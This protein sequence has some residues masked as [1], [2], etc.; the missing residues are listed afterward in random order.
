MSNPPHERAVELPPRIAAVLV[1]F[2]RAVAGLLA[3]SPGHR[4]LTRRMGVALALYLLLTASLGSYSVD[5]DGRVYLDFMRRLTGEP[6]TAPATHQFGSTIF[7]LPFFLVARALGAVGVHTLRGAPLEQVSMAVASSVALLLVVY[8]G[9]LLLRR[10]DL[11]AGPGV[12]ALAVVGTPLFYYAALQPTYKHAIDALFVMLE[13]ILLLSLLR[14]PSRGLLLALGVCLGI[15][16]TIRTANAALVPGM[17][18]PLLLRRNVRG[19]GSVLATAAVVAA[20]LF[21]LPPAFGISGGQVALP[22]LAAGAGP[23]V[24]SS[25]FFWCRNTTYHLTFTQCLHNKIGVSPDPAAPAKMLFSLHRGLFLWTPLTALAV[26]GFVLLARRRRD[27]RHYFL[28][29]GAAALG[30]LLVHMLWGD[31]WDNGFSFSQRFLAALFPLFLLGTAELV[32]RRRGLAL[33]ALSMCAVFSLGL[34]LTFF[35]GYQGIS[36]KDGVDRMVRLYTGG[37]RTPQQLVRKT[38]IAV[39]GRW[40]GH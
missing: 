33:T 3:E 2:P 35:F 11:P 19:A 7:M 12:L 15:S 29:L 6:T 20:I 24:A 28:G 39:R 13:S 26:V 17:L 31:F 10:L 37:E 18:L 40:L 9:W 30:L 27:E 4:F 23:I 32:R 22:R 21:A 8:L 5:N 1:R 16:I 38:A 36:A 34:A 25:N 14:R